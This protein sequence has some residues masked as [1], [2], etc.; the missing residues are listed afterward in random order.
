MA[1]VTELERVWDWIVSHPEAHDQG[2]WAHSFNRKNRVPDPAP[3][4][5]S[6][7]LCGTALCFAGTAVALHGHPLIWRWERE[8]LTTTL[9][10]GRW[11]AYEALDEFEEPEDIPYMA[12]K[13]LDLNPQD[14]EDLFDASNTRTDI[15]RILDDIEDRE[16]A[17]HIGLSREAAPV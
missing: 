9:R 10:G 16:M 2:L 8:M 7:P 15:R 11:V 3:I 6:E 1:N 12:M 4:R 17:S 14:A 5:D 13:I